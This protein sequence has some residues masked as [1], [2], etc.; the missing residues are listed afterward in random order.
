MCR[1]LTYF[2][3]QPILLENL[4]DKPTNS[5]I[6]QSHEA[7]EGT[8]GVNADGFGIAWYDFDIDSHPGVFKSIQP[9]WNDNN[10]IHLS[11]KIRSPC[12]L[13]HVRASTIGDVNQNNCH[14]FAYE[15]YAFA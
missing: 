12:F 5:L 6:K 13:A 11:Q 15:N 4:L 2:S 9:A 10:L 14:P 3:N 1:F 7:K 8:H